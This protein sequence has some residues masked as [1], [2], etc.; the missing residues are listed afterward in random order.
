MIAD[1]PTSALDVTVQAQIIELLG[2]LADELGMALIL[3]S[4]DL[5]VV[6]QLAQRVVVMYAGQVAEEGRTADVFRRRAH[7]YTEGLFAALPQRGAGRR[8]RA[9]PGTVPQPGQW[10]AGCAFHGRCPRG[11]EGCRA[12]PPPW[13]APGE[14]HRVRCFHPGDVA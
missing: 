2:T 5:G 12:A 6:G 7:P 3:I 9:I 14:D 10:P 1:E 8:L 11:D 13:A 4:H